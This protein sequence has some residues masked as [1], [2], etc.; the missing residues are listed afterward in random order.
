MKILRLLPGLSLAIVLSAQQ[1][2]P[3]AATPTAAPVAKLS[4]E[5]IVAERE[6]Y[7]QEVLAAIKGR[8][9]EP[10]EAV[11]KNIQRFKG[12]PAGRLPMIM[13]MGFGRSLGVSCTHCHVPG[14]WEKEDKP[15]KQIAREM[16]ALSEKINKELLPAIKNLDSKQPLVNCTTCHRGEV[17]PATNLPNHPARPPTAPKQAD[18]E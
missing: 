18:T 5:E 14:E 16:S 8:E 1:P 4:A 2:A 9:K 12:V 6:K 11:F 15:Q 10:A 7:V 13:N 17:K 3:L